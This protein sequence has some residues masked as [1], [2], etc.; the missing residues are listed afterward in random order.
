PANLGDDFE[1]GTAGVYIR[2]PKDGSAGHRYDIAANRWT[3]VP[4]RPARTEPAVGASASKVVVWGGILGE[5][6]GTGDVLDLTTNTWRPM[7]TARAPTGRYVRWATV[8]DGKLVTWS[9]ASAPGKLPDLVD[10]G[11]YDI[12]AD[13][14]TPIPP[15]N[16]P[17]ADQNV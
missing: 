8:R 15:A 17:A 16:A 1:T 11:L 12:A 2:L 3:P 4:K 10:G 6:H 14:W 13:R 5:P 7:S 9:G